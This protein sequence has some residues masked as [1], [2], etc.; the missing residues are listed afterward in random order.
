MRWSVTSV[1]NIWVLSALIV[2]VKAIAS[3][4]LKGFIPV[5]ENA[6]TVRDNHKAAW[7]VIVLAVRNVKQAII[8]KQAGGGASLCVVSVHQ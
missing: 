6:K 4:V 2:P 3:S 7:I 5:M 8:Q 1:V